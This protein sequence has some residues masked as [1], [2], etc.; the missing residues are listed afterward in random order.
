MNA[1]V[2]IWD[3]E[4]RLWDILLMHDVTLVCLERVGCIVFDI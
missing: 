4:K 2:V 1:S 3:H